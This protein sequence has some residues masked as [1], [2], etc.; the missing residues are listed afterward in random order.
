MAPLWPATASAQECDAAE[1]LRKLDE[2]L[3][4][5]SD[6][7]LTIE[8]VNQIPGKD[9]RTM[10]MKVNTRGAKRY[11][12][13]LAPGDVKGTKVLSL[14]R[15][16]MYV[17][18]PAY[19]KVRRITSHTTDQGFMGTTLS[20]DDMATT[21]YGEVYDGASCRVEAGHSIVRGVPK[22]DAQ[23]AYGSVV[24]KL[25]ADKTLPVELKYF[26]TSGKHV[27]TETR[28]DYDCRGE[29]CNPNSISMVDHT[30]GGAKTLLK[31]TSWK[32]D[33]GFSDS[34]FSRRAL[35]RAR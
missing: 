4:A 23:I 27:K 34:L 18:L 30:R 10:R 3:N 29:F 16:K 5:A 2:R 12:E 20:H 15:S 28:S 21:H 17:Y 22:K 26:S 24:F 33:T 13:F 25:T 32:K 9:D 7:A 1:V 6:L 11:T 31:T 14:S 8:I 19:Q 35:Q